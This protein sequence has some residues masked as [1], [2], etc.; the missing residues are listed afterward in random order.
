MTNTDKDYH[1]AAIWAEH[2]MTLPKN[3]R[4]ALRGKPA[5]D[6]GRSVLDRALGGRPSIDPNAAPGQRS[7][8][9]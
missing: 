1:A 6:F 9:R 8:P 4:T 3:S 2:D 5:A 7:R